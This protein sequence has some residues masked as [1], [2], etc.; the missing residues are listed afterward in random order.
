[1]YFIF[2]VT[3]SIYM[4]GQNEICSDIVHWLAVILGPAGGV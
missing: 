2:L 4:S 3:Y 1:M